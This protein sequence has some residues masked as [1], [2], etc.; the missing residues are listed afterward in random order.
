ML[1]TFAPLIDAARDLD[2]SD[3]AAARAELERR[4]PSDGPAAQ[5]LNAE[6]V[7]LYRAGELA[8]RGAP[9]VRFG[10]VA[11][12]SPESADHSIDV[13]VMEGPGPRHRHPQGEVD[14]CVRLAGD[15]KFDGQPAGWVV[16]GP[17]SVHVPTV[18]DGEMLI[19]YLLPQGGIEFL[20]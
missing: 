14:Y 6:L 10:R 1:D 4:F 18:S 5:A 12:P 8:Q 19:A 2:L 15:P 16:Y 13:V 3:P 11:K 17:D 20:E 7:R 9:P